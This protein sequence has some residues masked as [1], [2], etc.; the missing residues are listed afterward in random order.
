M[1]LPLKQYTD[2]LNDYLRPEWPKATLLLVILLTTTALQLVSPQII[3]RFIDSALTRA[4]IEILVQLAVLFILVG[5]VYQVLSVGATYLGQDVGWSATNRL[6]EDLA[7]H[8]LGLDPSFFHERTPGELIERL[9]GDI[10]ALANFFSQIVVRVLG[11]GILVAGTL[12]VLYH[13]DWRVGL[14]LTGF[15]AIAMFVLNRARGL[16]VPQQREERQASAN[17][18]GFIEER[19]AGLDDIRANGAGHYTMLRLYERLRDLFVKGRRAAMLRAVTWLLMIG[20]FTVGNILTLGLGAYLF[21]IGSITIGTVYLFFQ[22]TEMLERPLEQITNQLQELQRAT[23]SIQRIAELRAIRTRIVDGPGA[24]M[25]AGALPIEFENVSFAYEDEVKAD[26]DLVLRDLSFRLEPGRI[27]GLLGRTGSG[28]TTISR[29]LF[30]FYDPTAGTIR[31]GGVDTRQARLSELRHRVAIVSQDVQLFSGTVRN[32]LTFFD[33][34][35][36]DE[37]IREVVAELGLESW[38]ASLP[39]GLDTELAS[40]GAGLSAGEAQLLAFV[41]VFLRDPGIVILD[42][43]SSRLDPATERLIE[44]AVDKL[45]ENR[46]G[47]V[48]AH[49]LATVERADDIMIL[50]GGRIGEHGNR[51]ALRR[52]PGSR[53]SKLLR[54]G[55]EEVLT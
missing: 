37:R 18:F 11:S 28:K 8:C 55:L 3:R 25:P 42:E 36:G 52:D 13:E 35:I 9:D 20:L 19:L 4:P 34:S 1:R 6:R 7:R 26:A 12:I 22:Y 54:T 46:T 2:L 49:R 43:A 38:Y 33:R 24:W 16:A 40:G 27:L 32:N 14:V 23:A 41:R 5:L 47:V 50:D 44:R 29:L 51:E 17:L 15:A 48:I 53:F 31:L 39:N 30:R 45:L 21:L 10:T